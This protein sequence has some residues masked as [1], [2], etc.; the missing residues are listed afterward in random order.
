MAYWMTTHWPARVG[1]D[2][3][4][5][6]GVWVVEGR[7]HIIGRMQPGDQV[8]V[9][10]SG[11]GRTA[12]KIHPDGTSELLP[13]RSGRQGV[14]M[15]VEVSER[16][17]AKDDAEPE[18]YTDGTRLW[19]RWCAPTTTLNSVGFVP[20]KEIARILGYKE[21][22]AFRGFGHEHSGL[23]EVSP[24]AFEAIKA[25]YLDSSAAS[26]AEKLS[27]A[28]AAIRRGG[29]GGEGEIHKKM[30]AAIAADPGGVLGEVGL[31]FVR[32]EYPFATGDRIDVLLQDRAGRYVVVEIEP[33]CAEK[34]IAGP[35]QCM[36]YRALLAYILDRPVDEVRSILASRSIHAK[37]SR[38][39][40]E[41]GIEPKMV[42]IDV[43]AVV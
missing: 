28:E 2:T 43:G 9:Y 25:A 16:A 36:K 40:G 21:N 17:F 4:H 20:R 6:P 26:D 39:C 3:S 10:E 12:R 5:S 15:L 13:C 35:L 37:V 19:W 14:V 27:R 30:K 11:S 23:M 32:V 31:K 18:E 24:V 29:P 42:R 41:Y 1:E 8:W 7:Q 38:K 33:D 34:E 22:Y